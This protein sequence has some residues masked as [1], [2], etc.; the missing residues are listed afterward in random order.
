MGVHCYKSDG[1]AFL[2]RSYGNANVNH[3]TSEL[4]L[5]LPPT[6]CSAFTSP[7]VQRERRRQAVAFTCGFCYSTRLTKLAVC[8][9]DAN[10]VTT[11][12]PRGVQNFSRYLPRSIV[13]IAALLFLPQ[14]PRPQ[15]PHTY[16]QTH[17]A[18]ALPRGAKS[19]WTFG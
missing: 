3:L 11:Q 13:Y 2:H 14:T 7:A 19:F 12:R 15:Q 1:R 10:G 16:R 9:H 8:F 6:P 4:S 17:C 5:T 18:C